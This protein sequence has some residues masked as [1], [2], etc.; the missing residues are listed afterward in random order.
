MKGLITIAVREIVERRAVA[1]AAAAAALIPLV[2]PYF[3]L[4]SATAEDVRG[5]MA[6]G[7]RTT[8]TV[9]PARRSLRSEDMR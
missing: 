4:G 7:M 3:S 1:G 9:I 5:A 8:E 6:W 2:L